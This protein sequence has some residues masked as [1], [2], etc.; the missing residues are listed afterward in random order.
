MLLTDSRIRINQDDNRAY[1]R[2]IDHIRILGYEL[3][4]DTALKNLTECTA[5]FM[6]YDAKEFMEEHGRKPTA[7]ELAKQPLC[8]GWKE[9]IEDWNKDIEANSKDAQGELERLLSVV[10]TT[11]I[12]INNVT[13]VS[14]FEETEEYVCALNDAH[15]FINSTLSHLTDK[16]TK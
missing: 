3:D 6:N 5:A 12:R 13:R 2:L 4:Y 9:D 15:R 7:N 10:L 14:T 8:K 11:L 16:D 1:I